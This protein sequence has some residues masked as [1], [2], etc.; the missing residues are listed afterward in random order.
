MRSWGLVGCVLLLSV[1]S[2]NTA[3]QTAPAQRVLE[4]RYTPAPRAQIAIWIENAAGELMRT[5][6]L[7]DAVAM[8]GIGN[9]PGA[10][11]M[12]SGFRWPYGRREGVLP[13]WAHQ[14]ASAQGAQQFKRV[15]FQLRDSEGSA[16]KS[17]DD[18]SD[19]DY[20]CLSF[21]PARSSKDALDAVSCAS[22]FSSDKGRYMTA[23]DVAAGY[24]EPYEDIVS[25]VGRIEP[26]SLESLYPPRR[27]AQR[28]VRAD[29]YD[30]A[31]I[32]DYPAHARAVMP[33]IDEVTMAT[34]LGGE[35]AKLLFPLPTAWPDGGYRACLEINVEGDYNSSFNPQFYRTPQTPVAAWDDWASRK[36]FGYPYRGQPSVVYCLD[37]AI[38]GDNARTF[39]T[40]QPTGTPG[41]WDT[42][43]PS[44]G[45]L[46]P[47]DGMTDDP[48]KAQ[49]SGA[50]RLRRDSTG[51]R[52]TAIVRPAGACMNNRA[53]T[54]VSEL[55]ISGYREERHAHEWA[56]LSFRAAQDDVALFRYELRF[57][58]DPITDATSFIRAQP[59]KNATI[60][61]EELRIPTNTPPG[62]LISIDVGGFVALNHYYIGVRAIDDCGEAS[63]VQVVE[64]STPER[65][66]A[67]VTPCFIATAAYD[68]PLAA[69]VGAL[70][71]F[72]DRQ[73]ANN[74]L[75]RML[76]EAYW[77]IGP[78]L[79]QQITQHDSLRQLAR[80][81]LSP[82]VAAVRALD[83]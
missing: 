62:A 23:S 15:I 12:N 79:A 9:R 61:G 46:A 20:F 26:L 68:S 64:F 75:G 3:A 67:T 25:R 6:G 77:Q 7:T 13:I 55:A 24:G 10:S 41:T 56:T 31:D 1:S 74:T 50:D 40:S 59:L 54:A 16:S 11:Q 58:I 72:R 4:L 29:C 42:A 38:G 65:K 48:V 82:L 49:G 22:V 80:W 8:R 30:H 27:D 63:P 45:A 73:L 36:G 76:V 33:E 47:M 51:S 52:L 66:F 37:F 39:E 28:C 60:A 83:E 81:I 44:F 14:R 21:V 17:S 71:R 5:I 2:S 34:P 69:Q 19:D 57:S 70:R 35:Q 18:E 32:A 43:A 53:P 78:P